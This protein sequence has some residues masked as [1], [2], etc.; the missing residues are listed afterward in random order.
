MDELVRLSAKQER[1]GLRSRCLQKIRE[2]FFE[3]GFLEV[4]TPVRSSS[5][6]PEEHIHAFESEAGFLLPSPE[7]HMKGL[8]AAGYEKIFQ[9]GPVFRKGEKGRF[10]L[11]EFTLLEWYRA[12]ADYNAL[13]G[14][15]ERMV[16][17]ICEELFKSR[18]LCYQGSSI[19]VTPPWP[20][21][22]VQEAFQESA[23]WDPLQEKNPER[24]ERDLVEK[25]VPR[26]DPEKPVFLFDF[27][28]Y[29]ASLARK[30]ISDPRIAERLELFA[31][32]LELANGFS[33]LTD[34]GEQRLRFELVNESRKARGERP[35]TVPENFLA[36]VERMPP[37]AGIALGVDRMLMLLTDAARIGDVVACEPD[38][39]L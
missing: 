30:K 28:D 15:C 29:E 5:L 25:V 36:F 35:C 12:R 11:P 17:W 13:A 8:L 19:D 7:I 18:I 10:H 22:T 39:M 27:P 34:P 33:E 24:F 26:L 21:C 37:S 32:Q 6:I 14:D 3:E 20:R 38:E 4:T 9:I 2:F 1:L 31:G 16:L 23:G